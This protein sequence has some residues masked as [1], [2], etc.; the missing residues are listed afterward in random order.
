MKDILAEK[1][2]PTVPPGI[3]PYKKE[4]QTPPKKLLGDIQRL[5]CNG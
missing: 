3:G 4:K 1:K 5:K 2:N